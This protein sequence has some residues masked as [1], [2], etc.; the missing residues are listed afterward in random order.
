MHA[1]DAVRRVGDIPE[2]VAN[3]MR[4]RSW[5]DDPRC[6]PFERLRLLNLP[7]FGFDGQEQ[8][9][10]MVV[11]AEIADE[12][13]AIF[14]SL[15]ARSFPI[16]SMRRIDSFDGDD[17]ASM[18]ADNS[19]AFNFRVI[20]G[21]A[22]L[23]HHAL[24]LAV[25]INPRENP[26]IVHGVVHPPSARDF[27]DRSKSRPGMI[28]ADSEV[29]ALFRDHGWYWGGDWSDMPDYHHFSKRIRGA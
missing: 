12:V 9:G 23:S 16:R 21:S 6:P 3:E 13:V 2:S 11:A 24:G 19:S 1:V 18:E 15:A 20:P 5:R 25:D 29:V 26:M 28:T 10:E 7:F 17:D 8:A 27:L 14:E 4:G 22:S